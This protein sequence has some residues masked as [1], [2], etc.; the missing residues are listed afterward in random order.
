[1]GVELAAD[2]HARRLGVAE[3]ALIF[4]VVPNSP[5]ARAGLRPS[6]MDPGSGGVRL[7]DVIVAIDSKPVKRAEDVFSL[8]DGYHAGEKVTVG[9]ERQGQR[10]DVS[11]TL[12][13]A[14]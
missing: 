10:L 14:R 2:Q 5:A 9:I 3:G 7:G 13:A 8:L 11:L 6:R 4:S 1:M 12:A